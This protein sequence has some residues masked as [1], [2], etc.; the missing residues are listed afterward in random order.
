MTRVTSDTEAPPRDGAA[1]VPPT[2]GGGPPT[3]GGDG[4]GGGGGRTRRRFGVPLVP[5]L[6]ALLVLLV[7]A[8]AFLWF[9]RPDDSPVSTGDYAS[10]LQAARSA[11]VDFSS[12]DHLTLDDDLEQIRRVTTEDFGEQS[13]AELEEQREGILQA[14]AVVNVEV[15]GAGVTLADEQD[16]TVILLLQATTESAADPRPSVTKYRVEATLEK[17]GDRWLLS[18]ISGR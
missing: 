15:I 9:T 18:G 12:F 3:T 17:D 16:A 4:E 6:A 8:A 2:T 5:V 11:V 10:A 1:G 7:A 13:V 14:Q